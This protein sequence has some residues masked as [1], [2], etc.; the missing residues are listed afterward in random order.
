[1]K[2]FF[3]LAKNGIR[4]FCLSRGLGDV[5]IGQGWGCGGGG[6]CVCVCACVCVCVCVCVCAV[7][8]THVAPRTERIVE[9]D[10][11]GVCKKKI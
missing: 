11:G 1:M 5:Y 10:V 9:I 6:V 7:S 3:F 2:F 4:D 8:Y